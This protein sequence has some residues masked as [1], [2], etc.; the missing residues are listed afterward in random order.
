MPEINIWWSH[1]GKSYHNFSQGAVKSGSG[2]PESW[3]EMFALYTEI[4]T[5]KCFKLMH[6]RYQAIIWSNVDLSS[7]WSYNLSKLNQLSL[8]DAHGQEV[9][10]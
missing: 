1:C 7:T 10:T 8:L 2:R 3:K 5:T 9:K 6:W 4:A